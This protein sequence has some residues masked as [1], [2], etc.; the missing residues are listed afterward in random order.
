MDKSGKASRCYQIVKSPRQGCQ[1]QRGVGP[2]RHCI[3][4]FH[5]LG[6]GL[7]YD[8]TDRE[9]TV[10]IKSYFDGNTAT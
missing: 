8:I 1:V 7:R 9:I 10:L 2:Q 5:R 6:M 4:L 3:A